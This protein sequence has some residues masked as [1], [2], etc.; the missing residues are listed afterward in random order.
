MAGGPWAALTPSGVP[1][2][3]TDIASPGAELKEGCMGAASNGISDLSGI[4]QLS[5]SKDLPLHFSSHNQSAQLQRG[6][7]RTRTTLKPE[8]TDSESELH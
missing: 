2:L 6:Q 4:Y 5:I 7:N 8:H 3:F 1:D